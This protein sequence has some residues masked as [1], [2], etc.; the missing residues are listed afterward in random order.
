MNFHVALNCTTVDLE[1][2]ASELTFLVCKICS[3]CV[4]ARMRVCM[5]APVSVFLS[6]GNT[7]M[8]AFGYKKVRNQVFLVLPSILFFETSLSLNLDIT[9]CFAWRASELLGSVCLASQDQGYS[10]LCS[11]FP[12][13]LGWWNAQFGEGLKECHNQFSQT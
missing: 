12:W 4:C 11:T 10:H 9:S 7:F 1:R 6:G 8:C 2:Q 5:C 13:L 3:V